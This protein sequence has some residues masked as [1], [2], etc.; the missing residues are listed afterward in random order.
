M[1][2]REGSRLNLGPVSDVALCSTHQSEVWGSPQLLG[3]EEAGM[4]LLAAN[5]TTHAK[6]CL[7]IA[8]SFTL[9]ITV[10]KTVSNAKHL[11]WLHSEESI[12]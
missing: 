11:G 1:G 2:R 8:S 12:A 9:L 5:A 10:G 3:E 7:T 6:R 4:G